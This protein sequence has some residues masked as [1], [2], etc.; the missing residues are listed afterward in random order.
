[1]DEPSGLDRTAETVGF[2]YCKD[3]EEVGEGEGGRQFGWRSVRRSLLGG[4]LGWRRGLTGNASLR[5]HTELGL[6]FG[7]GFGLGL[8][9]RCR[10]DRRSL[11]AI[12]RGHHGTATKKG[13]L[14]K[15]KQNWKAINR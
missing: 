11:S 10:D 4:T 13:N 8:F 1:M 7:F 6:G 9:H 3:W 15:M 14:R 12:G 2:D 5:S